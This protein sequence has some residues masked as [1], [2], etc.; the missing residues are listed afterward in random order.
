MT[1]SDAEVPG[2]GSPLAGL[3][4]IDSDTHYSEPYDLWTSEAPAKYKDRVPNVTPGS[5]GKLHWFFDGDELFTAGG[6]SFVTREGEKI[7]FFEKDFTTFE[8]WNVIHEA[9]YDPR[10]RVKFLDETG[11]WAQ[12]TYPTPLGNSRACLGA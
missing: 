7:P 12:I 9:S 4:L 8:G 11:A 6:S 10:A 5:D 3:K 1:I 2:V